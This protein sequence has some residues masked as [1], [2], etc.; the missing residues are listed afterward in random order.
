MQ[1][2]S[3]LYPA[4]AS[5]A[6]KTLQALI[7]TLCLAAAYGATGD[8]L[9]TGAA[10]GTPGAWG[11]NLSSVFDGDLT[12]EWFGPNPAGAWAGTDFGAGISLRLNAY[13]IAAQVSGYDDQ[14]NRLAGATIQ[15][16]DDCTFAT[17]VVTLDTIPNS[18]FY[19]RFDIGPRTQRFVNPPAGYRCYRFVSGPYGWG[20]IAELQWIGAAGM[21][22]VPARPVMP[23]IAP[24]A[25]AFPSGSAGI[26]IAS[27]TTSARIY[28]TVDGTQ[29]SN[30][31][32]VLYTGPF[33]LSV[34]AATVLQAVA[35]DSTLSTPLSAVTIGRYRN[36]AFKPKDDW[37]DDQGILI[38]AHA[39]GIS[40][41]FAGRYYWVGQ[42]ANKANS[43]NDIGA[44]EG[45]WMYSSADL[46]NWHFEG[47]ILDN[48]QSAGTAWR[49]VERPHLLHNAA[50]GNYVLWAHMTN[51]HDG[52]DRAGVA[53]AASITGPWAWRTVTLNPDN[54]GFKD[55]S[56]FQEIDGTAYAVYVN[57]AQ[58]GIT[59][60]RLS[61]DYQTSSGT[62][63]HV[64]NTNGD[65]APVLFNRNGNYF[66]IRSAP[67]YYD[68]VNSLFSLR[69]A[70]CAACSSPLGSFGSFSDLFSPAPGINSPYNCQSSA[71]L[72]IPDRQDAYVLLCD[73]YSPASLYSSRQS[74]VPL[75]F[76]SST[77]VRGTTPA[78]WDLT[79]WSAVK[80][81]FPLPSPV[82]H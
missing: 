80:S 57:G 47:Q 45:V 32:G 17:G 68:S 77:T 70:V 78:A 82:V 31:N 63:S 24:G 1:V 15:A 59:I 23:V 20:G 42:L 6:R 29:P 19:A 55:F 56:L 21:A 73:F 3:I 13:R 64:T 16:S 28:Y 69:Y 9:Y 10:I 75:T 43:G 41:P 26:T 50:H 49:F 33:T 79:L 62:S 35:Y 72:T 8:V 30:T 27:A 44:N 25:G 38:E 67:N 51:A 46:L 61:S 66:L 39:G 81:L 34:G 40:G 54:N 4:A 58:D 37:Y 74:W 52:T 18:P 53:T 22:G 7:Y 48:G 5:A 36:Y 76:P 71:M 11:T 12:T 14:I 2:D 65:E 60:S